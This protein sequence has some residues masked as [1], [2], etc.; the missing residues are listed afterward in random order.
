MENQSIISFD[1][2]QK[3]VEAN[4]SVCFY[5]STPKC[6]VCKILKPK[7]VEL[8]G[9][10]FPQIRFVYVDLNEAKEIAGQLSVFAVPTILIYFDSKEVIR[11]SRNISLEM[12]GEQ[13]ERYYQLMF[14]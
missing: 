4:P 11:A 3:F 2:F 8:I 9:T 12:L 6:N 10:K 7:V 1:E 5:L 13:I 14:E